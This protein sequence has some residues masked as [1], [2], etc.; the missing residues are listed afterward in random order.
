MSR[1]RIRPRVEMQRDY[2]YVGLYRHDYQDLQIKR[3]WGWQTI[4]TEEVPPYVG[5]YFAVGGC[6]WVSKFGG[7]YT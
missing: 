3:W 7:L 6:G 1:Y 5:C 2:G 4:D